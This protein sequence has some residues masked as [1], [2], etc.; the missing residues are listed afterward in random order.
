MK[1]F[2]FVAQTWIFKCRSLLL[3]IYESMARRRLCGG[4]VILIL[5]LQ[6][7]ALNKVWWQPIWLHGRPYCWVACPYMEMIVR[8]QIRIERRK[9]Q[10]SDL[11][12]KD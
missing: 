2:D 7:V 10:F 6:V 4:I 3:P 1:K 5:L 12:S 9:F 11:H 8:F